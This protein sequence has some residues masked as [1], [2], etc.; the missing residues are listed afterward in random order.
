MRKKNIMIWHVAMSTF[1]LNRVCELVKE[2]TTGV[3]VFKNCDLKAIVEVVL[4]FTDRE[5][6]VDQLYNHLRHWRAMWVHACRL[7]M[8][9]EVRWVEKTSSIMM[10]DDAY[11]AHIK[12]RSVHLLFHFIHFHTMHEDLTILIT[13]DSP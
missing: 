3:Q 2:G 9:E 12:V 13:A 1:V 6:G 5:V 10:E 11:Y 8:L 7:K 4:K